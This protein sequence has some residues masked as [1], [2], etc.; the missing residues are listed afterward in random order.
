MYLVQQDCE[1]CCEKSEQ[2]S[3]HPTSFWSPSVFLVICI[4]LVCWKDAAIGGRESSNV[5]SPDVLLVSLMAL[6]LSLLL[7]LGNSPMVL[8][9]SN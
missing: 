1:V 2:A 6:Y 5:D 9:A 8:S 3:M 7:I 4:C